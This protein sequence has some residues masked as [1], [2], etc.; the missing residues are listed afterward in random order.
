MNNRS[1]NI[2]KKAIYWS[3]LLISLTNFNLF[4]I[5]AIH[6]PI[7][8]F[9][10][11][12]PI[13]VFFVFEKF[14]KTLPKLKNPEILFL[15]GYFLLINLINFSNVRWSSLS[16]SILYLIFGFYICQYK[17]LVTKEVLLKVSKV[18]I[19][20]YVIN[21]IL[22]QVAYYLLNNFDSV[23]WLLQGA[24][25]LRDERM[26]F[27]GF[28]SEPSYAAFV[29]LIAFFVY[30]RLSIDTMK[31]KLITFFSLSWALMAIASVFGYIILMI[32]LYDWLTKGNYLKAKY[33]IIAIMFL[34]FVILFLQISSH[35]GESRLL[36]LFYLVMSAKFNLDDLRVL[37]GSAFMRVGPFFSYM[38]EFDI[39]DMKKYIGHGAGV[40]AF[41]F[42]YLFD[43][44]IDV[45]IKGN[46]PGTLKLGFIPG[47][48]YDYGIVG[49]FL[50]F[51]FILK[52][53]IPKIISIET[54]IF[55]FLF[56]NASLNTQLFWYVWAMLYLLNH[57]LNHAAL[58]SNMNR[59]ISV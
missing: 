8:I 16:Y 4:K 49:C 44:A 39:F 18:I 14:I 59:K 19:W 5:E 32:V 20:L 6:A 22:A 29:M 40:S 43:D 55:L 52:R 48:L 35:G 53:A 21:I 25:D 26:R 13:F 46:L 27:Y 38:E 54:L 57:N 47:F 10:L 23:N 51:A 58:N 9:I 30:T 37:S 34:S 24:V 1:W 28:S 42:G 33:L 11:T 36:K 12:F 31:M 3:L 56:V 50:V 7:T 45:S 2:R 15:A 17:Q 41:Y